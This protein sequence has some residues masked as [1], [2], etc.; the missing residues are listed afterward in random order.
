MEQLVFEKSGI[1]DLSVKLFLLLSAVSV[2]VNC[3]V[4]IVAN[5]NCRDPISKS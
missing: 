5:N 1:M 3:Q 4:S 2:V